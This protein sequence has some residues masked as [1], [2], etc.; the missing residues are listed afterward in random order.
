MIYNHHDNKTCTLLI[1]GSQGLWCGDI[2]CQGES[3]VILHRGDFTYCLVLS[4]T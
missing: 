2:S 1:Q 4:M 3:R